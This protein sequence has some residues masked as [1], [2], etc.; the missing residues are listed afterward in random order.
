MPRRGNSANLQ[1][2]E[3]QHKIRHS[4]NQT[5][6]RVYHT[7]TGSNGSRAP[8]RERVGQGEKNEHE[9]ENEQGDKH[10]K[11]RKEADYN[12]NEPPYSDAHRPQYVLCAHRQ[13]CA[14]QSRG[15]DSREA[16]P[17]SATMLLLL[18]DP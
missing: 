8:R 17:M 18:P 11:E 10:D 13:T 1:N 3:I 12:L 4:K 9:R 15:A 6:K 2:A 5:K 16:V 7:R 14:T